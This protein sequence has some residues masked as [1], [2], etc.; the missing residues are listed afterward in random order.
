MMQEIP[1]LHPR[2][3]LADTHLVVPLQK[4]A[5]AGV[6]AGLSVAAVIALALICRSVWRRLNPADASV[7]VS[8]SWHSGPKPPVSLEDSDRMQAV[9]AAMRHAWHGYERYAW[10]KDELRPDSKTGK[11]GVLG[12]MNGFTG[13]GASV[14]D[15][16]STLYIMGLHEEFGRCVSAPLP[17][18]PHQ[19]AL[20]VDLGKREKTLCTAAA[21]PCSNEALRRFMPCCGSLVMGCCV[22]FHGAVLYSV[23]HA[24]CRAHAWVADNMTFDPPDAK[25]TS[26]FETTIRVLGGLLAAHDLT[27]HRMFLDKAEDLGMRLLPAFDGTRTGALQPADRY[28][29]E[30]AFFVFS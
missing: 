12:G 18:L 23:L 17:A 27:G 25:L 30:R 11:T 28:S 3:A 2:H 6:V 16:M 20:A 19:P 24:L 21:G 10:G 4:P 5:R 15:A 9:Q 7:Y 14:V 1:H 8:V 22:G 13:L 29:F 26:F